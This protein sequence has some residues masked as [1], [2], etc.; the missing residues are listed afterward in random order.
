MPFAITSDVKINRLQYGEEA[1]APCHFFGPHILSHWL[2][3]YVRS[4][5]GIFR[6]H[7]NEYE[8][9][10]GE[11]FF[12]PPYVSTYYEADRDDPWDYQWLG[13]YGSGLAEIY[14][15]AGLSEH[16]PVRAVSP[17]VPRVLDA[18]LKQGENVRPCGAVS[19]AYAFL[20]ALS[21][22]APPPPANESKAYV[23]HAEDYLQRFIYKKVTVADIA[24]H[25]NIDRSYLTSLFK[26]HRGIST[27]QYILKVKMEAACGY[28]LATD[29]DVARIARS[30]GYDDPFVFSHA[31]KTLYGES[32]T[33][34]RKA[35]KVKSIFNLSL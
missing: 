26:K 17:A 31:F 7:E 4:G 29:Y 1:C 30:V 25:L 20:E 15:S 3:H 6:I 32:P 13:I 14:A 18:L 9:H 33:A 16:T 24:A 2:V 27:Q 34:W 12:I 8:V 28:L 21:E 22:N 23:E 5:R 10:A 19:L 35:Q 11:V